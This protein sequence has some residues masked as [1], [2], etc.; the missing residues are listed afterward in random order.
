[1]K[2]AFVL[3]DGLTTLDFTGF[4]DPVTRLALYPA[5]KDLTWDICAKGEYVTDDRGVVIKVQKVDPDL[6]AYDMVFVPGGFATRAL[7]NDRDFIAWL[8]TAEHTRYKVSVCTGA[9]LLGAAGFLH[10]KTATTN[11]PA[12]ELLA[13]YC[14]TIVTDHRIVEDGTTIT[15][16]G[17]SASLDLGLFVAELLS[18][19]ETARDIQKSMNYPYYQSAAIKR[20]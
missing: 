4:F 18:D 15:A 6:S 7:R 17:V 12:Y 16:G 5:G 13:P 20:V 19:T 9:L 14:K 3:F 1:M 2:I 11:A 8:R 10:H